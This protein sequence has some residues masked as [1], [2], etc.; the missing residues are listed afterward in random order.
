MDLHTLYSYQAISYPHLSTACT[1]NKFDIYKRHCSRP[2]QNNYY[3][4]YQKWTAYL[5]KTVMVQ[6]GMND[7][8]IDLVENIKFRS[9]IFIIQKLG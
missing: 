9:F 2:I 4:Y 1:H 5:K 6:N 3:S 7:A 8:I